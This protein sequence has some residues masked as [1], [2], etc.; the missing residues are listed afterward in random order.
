MVKLRLQRYGTKKRPF[1]RLVAADVRSPR[2]G[3]FIEQ[4][5][6]IDPISYT[7][8]LNLKDDRVKYWIEKGA[9]PTDTVRGIL[10]KSGL[11]PA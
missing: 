6:Y 2:D 1:Y 10:K 4:L 9:Q 11:I 5:G 3:K 8:K 7:E